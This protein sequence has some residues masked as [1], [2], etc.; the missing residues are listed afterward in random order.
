MII[1]DFIL[2][3]LSI[4]LIGSCN[5][6][7]TNLEI[8][9]FYAEGSVDS[10]HLENG[11][12]RFYGL[13]NHELCQEGNFSNGIRVGFWRYYTPVRDSIYWIQYYSKDSLIETN[14]PNYM[15]IDSDEGDFVAFQHKDTS[16]LLLLKIGIAERSNFEVNEYNDK[17]LEEVKGNSIIVYERS[18]SEI[19]TTCSRKYHFNKFTGKDKKNRNYILLTI[20]SF[21]DKN[22]LVEVTVRCAKN[23]IRLGEETF[24]SVMSNMFIKGERFFDSNISC[25]ILKNKVIS[26]SRNFS[27]G[28]NRPKN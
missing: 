12:W 2:I 9:D 7:D 4:Y 18:Y 16:R 10:N 22:L 15:T 3:I 20:N 23:D 25:E 14:I 6:K 13:K 8:R 26:S 21:L 5:Y 28:C 1:R 24:F 11:M 27:L 17:M 19:N